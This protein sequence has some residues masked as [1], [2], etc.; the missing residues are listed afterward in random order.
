MLAVD[1]AWNYLVRT[2]TVRKHYDVV[3]PVLTLTTKMGS[4]VDQFTITYVFVQFSEFV[5]ETISRDSFQA[6]NANITE[7]TMVMSFS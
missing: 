7:F 3:P 6:L 4:R 2:N 5:R 1:I